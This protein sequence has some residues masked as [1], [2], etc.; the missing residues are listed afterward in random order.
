MYEL[1][2]GVVSR[3]A[4]YIP[5]VCGQS[6]ITVEGTPLIDPGYSVDAIKPRSNCYLVMYDENDSSEMHAL[7]EGE[8]EAFD[9]AIANEDSVA[10]DSA[11]KNFTK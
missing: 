5:L 8:Y 2:D 1:V 3:T 7:T 9:R 10:F 6:V 4:F 11:F